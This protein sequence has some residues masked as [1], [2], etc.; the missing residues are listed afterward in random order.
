MMS[1]TSSSTGNSDTFLREYEETDLVRI[2]TCGSV[3]DG[4][5]TLIGR[6]FL[7]GSVLPTDTLEALEE[8]SKKHGTQNGVL[9][10]ALLTDG[11][12]A[13]RE[14]GIT[15][16]VAYRFFSTD[17]RSFI[18]ADSP[19]HEQYT[20]NMVTA[21]STAD[22]ALLLLDARN[23][24]LEQSKRHSFI[25]SLLGI[26]HAIVAINKMDLVDFSED[27]YEQ[28]KEDFLAF[29]QRLD[30]TDLHFV[31][32]SALQGDNVVEKSKNM[33]WYNG[34]TLLHL[35]NTVH[36][37]SDRNMIDFRFPVQYV[38]RPDANYRGYCGTVAS[39]FVRPGDSV[40]VF[41]SHKLTKI[42]SID[43][44]DGSLE[45]AVTPMSV[46]LTLEDEVDISRGDMII[47]V[48]NVPEQR[49]AFDA[50][51]VWM[52]EKPMKI[53]GNYLL[54]HTTHT[55][56]A[57][58]EQVRYAMDVNTLSR[59]KQSAL[60]LNEIGRCSLVVDEPIAADSYQRNRATGAF[61]LI[62]P[63]TNLTAAAGMILDRRSDEQAETQESS[64]DEHFPIFWLTGNTGAGKTTLASAVEQHVN[65][66]TPA[67]NAA[68]RRLIVLDGDEMRDTISTQEDLSPEGRK[69]HN[70]RVARLAKLL[71]QKGFLVLVSVIAPFEEVRTEISSICDPLWVYVKR[72]G[73]GAAD[74]PY[75]EPKN[76]DCLIDHDASDQQEAAQSLID[77]IISQL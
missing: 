17:D 18:I 33:P 60:A 62:D 47:P 53:E 48:N 20:R 73:L 22:V 8:D 68:A 55:T 52:D 19:G 30:I 63:A 34:G 46:T 41:P 57:S 44:F 12:K 56:N 75:E 9:D 66:S 51:I 70:L 21:A 23:G 50:M 42:K 26:K 7:D 3:D 11:L 15:I 24:V 43:T 49:K 65:S 5:S 28:I 16:D 36:V 61:I 64:S 40:V 74:R 35:L 77:F 69:A 37:A 14:Q 72:E 76:P 13:E 2:L 4:K 71:R 54:K 25:A 1:S 45:K 59:K 29:A 6:L 58:V 67:W 39:G 27:V 32:V 10:P 31:P 38:N